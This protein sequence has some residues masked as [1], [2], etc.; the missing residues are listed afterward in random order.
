MY[1][2]LRRTRGGLAVA[3]VAQRTCQGCRISL[4]VNEEIRARTSPDL[5]FCQSCGRILHAGL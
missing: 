1:D 5:V 2:G 3:E 4:P